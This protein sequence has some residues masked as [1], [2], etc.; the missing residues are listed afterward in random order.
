MFAALLTW[1]VKSQGAKT[2]GAAASGS[3]ISVALLMGMVEKNVDNK[4]E[5]VVTYVD[6]KHNQVSTDIRYMKKEQSEI[7]GILKVI[8]ER[9][10]QLNK[11]SKGE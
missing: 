5:T 10:Y 8:N 4:I 11:R 1:M 3:V 2:A 9:V 7:K 6:S